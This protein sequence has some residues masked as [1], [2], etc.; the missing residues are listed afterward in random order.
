MEAY[1]EGRSMTAANFL[2]AVAFVLICAVLG[3][4]LADAM[5]DASTIA[6]LAWGTR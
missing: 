4:A 1:R 5:T 6:D 3:L 2:A